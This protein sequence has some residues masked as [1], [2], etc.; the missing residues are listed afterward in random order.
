[1]QTTTI[2]QARVFPLVI[3]SLGLNE[4]ADAGLA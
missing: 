2:A 4:P 3:E 1:M